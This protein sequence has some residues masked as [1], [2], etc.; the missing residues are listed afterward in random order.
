MSNI[1][2]VYPHQRPAILVVGGLDCAHNLL[3]SL[4]VFDASAPIPWRQLDGPIAR[5]GHTATLLPDGSNVIIAG[6]V[7]SPNVVV[8]TTVERYDV[9]SGATYSV[10]RLGQPR[11]NH[12]AALV[13]RDFVLVI[14]GSNSASCEL[15]NPQTSVWSATGSLNIAREL[16]TATRLQLENVLVVGGTGPTGGWMDSAE[17]YVEATGSWTQVKS[18]RFS[19]LGHSATLLPDGT[20]LVAGGVDPANLMGRNQCEIFDPVAGS[21]TDAASLKGARA[22]HTAT[23]LSDGSV[24][25]VGGV[26]GPNHALNTAEIY[27]PIVDTWRPIASLHFAR[28]GHTT[29]LYNGE[30]LVVGGERYGT[31]QTYDSNNNTWNYVGVLNTHR[32]YHTANWINQAANPW[33]HMLPTIRGTLG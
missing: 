5:K 24:L 20:V 13:Y 6:G 7:I 30:A 9:T 4:E 18:P 22:W 15:Y 1:S 10:G 23:S 21:W 3:T 26:D 12:A 11:V 16:H 17:V 14:G 29:T 33:A 32:G 25:V 2:A 8:A 27:Q 31:C 28:V 19:R